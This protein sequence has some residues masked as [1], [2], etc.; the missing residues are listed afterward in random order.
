MNTCDSCSERRSV[1]AVKMVLMTILE[2]DKTCK[3]F[4]IFHFSL[5]NDPVNIYI[6]TKESDIEYEHY[7]QPSM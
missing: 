4:F 1:K 5:D 6:K 7:F 3:A 2:V